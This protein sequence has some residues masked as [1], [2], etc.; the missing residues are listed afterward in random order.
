MKLNCKKLIVALYENEMTQRELSKKSG[1]S[2]ATISGIKSGRKCSDTTG[3]K[4]AKA[5]NMPIDKLVE[6]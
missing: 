6:W 3:E 5:L 1:V 4:I 2:V